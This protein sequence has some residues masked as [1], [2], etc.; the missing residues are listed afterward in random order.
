M[1]YRIRNSSY[2]NTPD[3]AVPSMDTFPANRDNREFGSMADSMLIDMFEETKVDYD[4]EMIYDDY[5]RTTLMDHMPDKNKME[6]EE[7]RGGVNQN[8]GVLQLRYNGHRGEADTPY[9]PEIFT[10]F[11]GD[12]EPRGIAVDPD[13]KELRKQ[14]DS[15]NRFHRMSK[16][17]SPFVIDGVRAERREIADKQKMFKISRDRTRVFDRQIDGRVCGK[18]ASK[19]TNKSNVCSQVLV[20]SYGDHITDKA[21]TPQRKATLI[22]KN[23]IRDNKEYRDSATDQDM[24]FMRYTMRCKSAKQQNERKVVNRTTNEFG[25]TDNTKS[26]KALGILMKNVCQARVNL[27]A[28][29][30]TDMAASRQT[31]ATKTAPISKDIQIIT[32]AIKQDADFNTSDNT[33]VSKTATPQ[34]RVQQINVVDNDRYLNEMH[35]NNALAISKAAKHGNL[36]DALNNVVSDEKEIQA[37]SQIRSVKSAKREAFGGLN[38]NVDYDTD[39]SQS[40]MTH[41]YKASEKLI[42]ENKLINADWETFEGASDPTQLYKTAYHV[43]DTVSNVVDHDSVF[44]NNMNIER[45]SAGIGSKYT[46]RGH[47]TEDSRGGEKFNT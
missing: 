7:P 34:D 42:K 18:S 32:Q 20:Q 29:A 35:Y 25:T 13:F 41:Q 4:E 24:D 43:R 9:M 44:S 17:D 19:H 5:A 11:M 8:A 31:I 28:D 21:L 39:K 2:A 23:V 12:H 30:D 15:R 10:G 3:N 36:R 6:H 1:D 38:P 26:Y 40:Y 14:H 27:I 22:C 45:H 33:R 47:T 16:D 37:F 46:R